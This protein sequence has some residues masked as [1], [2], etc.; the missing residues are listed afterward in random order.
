MNDL[1]Y[2]NQI[3]AQPPQKPANSL[4]SGPIF[5]VFLGLIGL[6]LLTVIG[7]AVITLLTPQEPT[8]EVELARLY[9]QSVALDNTI[10]TY[11]PRVKSPSLRASSSSLTSILAELTT[12]AENTLT[13]VYGFGDSAL[14]TPSSKDAKIISDSDDLLERARMNGILDRYY[15]SQI[16]YRIHN[17]LILED[18]VLSETSNQDITSYIESSQAS[19]VQLEETFSNFSESK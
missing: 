10:S 7:F 9:Q 11:S 17:L 15:A 8:P 12:N 3:S 19:L 4:F 1:D 2:L 14:K 5:K 18:L 13:K 6:V 16:A